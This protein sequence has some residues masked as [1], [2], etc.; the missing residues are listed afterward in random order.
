VR[1]RRGAQPYRLQVNVRSHWKWI[2]GGAAQ[3]NSLGFLSRAISAPRGS[4]VRLWSP[5][6]RAYSWPIVVR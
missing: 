2:G 5:R 1:P 3:T 6:D 4:L